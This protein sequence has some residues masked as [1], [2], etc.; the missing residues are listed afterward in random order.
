MCASISFPK[1]TLKV[2]S[3]KHTLYICI[4]GI[5]TLIVK[6]TIIC[7][8]NKTEGKPYRYNRINHCE[9]FVEY[10]VGGNT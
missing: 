9:E 4:Y 8:A 2:A 6:L 7:I 5:E 3:N 10:S 1:S